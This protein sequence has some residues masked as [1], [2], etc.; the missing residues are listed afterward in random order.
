MA[1]TGGTLVEVDLSHSDAMKKLRRLQQTPIE[2]L[3]IIF[4]FLPSLSPF[5]SMAFFPSLFFFKSL[6][7]EKSSL[8]KSLSLL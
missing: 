5:F 2:V 7:L 8:L 6:S 3:K 1:A 4:I